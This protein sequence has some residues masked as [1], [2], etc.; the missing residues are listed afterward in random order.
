M[1]NIL[2]YVR[3]DWIIVLSVPVRFF[4][5]CNKKLLVDLRFFL[6]LV[7]IFEIEFCL[8]GLLEAEKANVFFWL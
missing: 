2:V 7:N 4:K 3:L 1:P 5:N 6:K 8:I